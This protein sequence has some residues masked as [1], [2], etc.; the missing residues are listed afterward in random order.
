MELTVE[1]VFRLLESRN[2]TKE[3]LESDYSIPPDYSNPPKKFNIQDYTDTIKLL[4]DSFWPGYR[5]KH[6]DTNELISGPITKL[7]DKYIHRVFTDVTKLDIHNLYPHTIYKLNN[8]KNQHKDVDPFNEEDWETNSLFKNGLIWNID[9]FPILFNFLFDQREIIRTMD[10]G[11]YMLLKRIFNYTW[12]AINNKYSFVKCRNS[13]EI[14]TTINNIENYIYD[15]FSKHVIY[16]NVDTA[17]FSAFSE[18]EEDIINKFNELGYD[19]SL[20][21]IRNFLPINR[22]DYVTS[23]FDLQVRGL[24]I[25]PNLREYLEKREKIV[26]ANREKMDLNKELPM[27]MKMATQIIGLDLVS[28]P[29]YPS[30]SSYGRWDREI[31]KSKATKKPEQIDA[32]DLSSIFDF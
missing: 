5:I 8:V 10:E 6:S 11:V 2:Y 17:Y 28:E 30:S 7:D 21:T 3:Y 23:E 20:T 15:T 24:K 26:L 19:F 13:S 32:D 9:Q 16:L 1:N 22:R 12:G 25:I 14:M 18:I 29:L 4:L 31:E 27:D